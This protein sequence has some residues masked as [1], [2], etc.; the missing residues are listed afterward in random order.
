M[1]E[2]GFWRSVKRGMIQLVRRPLYV[3]CMIVIPIATTFFLLN[4]MESGLPE[5][6][7][8]AII[9]LDH[10][11]MSREIGRTLGSLQMVDIRN[12]FN[13]Y[14][15]ARDAMQRGEIFGF[16]IIPSD[17]S[18]KVLAGRKPEI[19]FYTNL[20]YYVP[21]S[22]LFKGFKM[23]SVLASG[24]VVKTVLTSVG[25]PE[26]KIMPM[27]Q[28]YS[29]HTHPL[30]NPW[31]SYAIYLG[32]SFAPCILAL[33]I[34]LVTVFSIGTEIK[35][36]T[37]RDWLRNANGSIFVA[38][39]GKLLPQTIIFAVV[40]VFMQSLLFGYYHFPL[41]GDAWN[42]ITGIILMVVAT[43]SF[44][45][46][47]YSVL[48]NL[49]LALSVCSLIGVLSF[50]VAGFSF[51]VN[52]MYGFLAI[53]SY[54]LPIRYYFLIYVDQALNGIPLYFS[55]IYYAALLVFPLVAMTMVWR[56]K[57]ACKNPVYLP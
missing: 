24:A 39:G 9:D 14:S 27:L 7:P 44:A 51:P 19:S 46:F 54:I 35:Y 38:L 45:V 26:Y 57:R 1:I 8:A 52:D 43:Q 34:L 30:G 3:V 10:T 15:E 21:G 42:M 16:F 32:N 11:E 20:T 50:S 47:I 37:S 56:L 12:K 29:L 2:T 33:M 5:K 4:L 53:F 25:M 28:P 6:V 49:R 31:M 55:R 40:G 13:S 18:Q 41:N 23:T 48:P 17:F 22:L 36:N